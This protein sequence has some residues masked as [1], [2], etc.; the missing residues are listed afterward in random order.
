M[1]KIVTAVNVMIA[2]HELITNV[3]RGEHG[4]ELF[5]LYKKKYKWSI[6]RSA[7]GDAFSLH[8]YPA[9][10]ELEELAALEPYEWEDFADMV[11]YKTR[12]IPGREALQS[13]EELYGIVSELA[14]GIGAV[15]DDIIGDDGL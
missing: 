11:S 9:R 2:H 7:S 4:S 12:D 8:Y 14:F 5:F 15:L 10:Q 1:S 13:F 3:I 6:V